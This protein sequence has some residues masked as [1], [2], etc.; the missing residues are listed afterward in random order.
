VHQSGAGHIFFQQGGDVAETANSISGSVTPGYPDKSFP[1]L[2]KTLRI[3][4][5]AQGRAPLSQ[6][7]EM[8]ARFIPKHEGEQKHVLC[9][10][11]HGNR[12]RRPG[13][14]TQAEFVVAHFVCDCDAEPS[15]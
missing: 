6:S 12:L 15:A 7:S 5:G 14:N 10:T 1:N 13:A 8:D 4:L 3:D 2:G 11:F 9:Q